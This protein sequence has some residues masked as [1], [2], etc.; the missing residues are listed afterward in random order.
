M[1]T[2]F[3]KG[4]GGFPVVQNPYPVYT[5]AEA[6]A[7]GQKIGSI[8]GAQIGRDV[9]AQRRLEFDMAREARLVQQQDAVRE[10]Q[11]QETVNSWRIPEKTEFNNVQ[12]AAGNYAAKAIEAANKLKTELDAGNILPKD[13]AA[14]MGSLEASLAQFKTAQE[15][16]DQR[17]NKYLAGIDDNTISNANKPEDM[18]VYSQ[19]FS[20]K[21]TL[22]YSNTKDGQ[23]KITG[24]YNDL[25]G[26]PAEISLPM[27]EIDRMPEILYKPTVKIQ[28]HKVSDINS[29]IE[30]KLNDS[31]SKTSEDGPRGIAELSYQ[32]QNSKKA[33]EDTIGQL[34]ENSFQQYVDQLGEGDETKRY[35]QYALDTDLKTKNNVE[36][37]INGL[38]NNAISAN[39]KN[40]LNKG[41]TYED[42]EAIL[43]S[44][45]TVIIKG[46]DGNEA[47]NI[48][49]FFKD[50]LKQE[51][52]NDFYLTYNN[53]LARKRGDLSKI[54]FT[55][56]SDQLKFLQQEEKIVKSKAN[57]DKINNPSLGKNKKSNITEFDKSLEGFTN[58]FIDFN[59]NNEFS[60]VKTDALGSVIPRESSR[61][62]VK[63]IG[64]KLKN[65]PNLGNLVLGQ[66]QIEVGD[67]EKL[68]DVYYNDIGD[69]KTGFKNMDEAIKEGYYPRFVIKGQKFTPVD[70]ITL[71]ELLDPERLQEYIRNGS[72]L[73]KVN[74]NPKI[75]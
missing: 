23:I 71:E 35:I 50:K 8:E 11:F 56:R 65:T 24:T 20:N 41:G 6:I 37:A 64:K 43:N 19:M 2:Y 74:N 12:I 29:I 59:K 10:V 9:Q 28:D 55:D 40:A 70:G 57:I 7:E 36:N 32:V 66:Q 58:Y 4:F 33:G 51:Y 22:E 31:L 63:R 45:E 39:L 62:K 38:N 18:Q 42:I 75:K 60:S 34:A 17:G 61:E 53:E 5:D 54:E 49:T 13:F 14:G 73:D 3:S 48:G 25:D 68:E 44:R 30:A 72:T 15:T 26:S 69:E 52:I 46:E 1:A 16:W 47:V 67:D 27:S 21:G